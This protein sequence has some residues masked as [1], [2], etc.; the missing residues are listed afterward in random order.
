MQYSARR[1]GVGLI[2]RPTCVV[3]I[4][5]NVLRSLHQPQHEHNLIQISS[6]RYDRHSPCHPSPAISLNASVLIAQVLAVSMVTWELLRW[7]R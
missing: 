2:F 1:Q 4:P 6:A 3:Q 5:Q 7:S